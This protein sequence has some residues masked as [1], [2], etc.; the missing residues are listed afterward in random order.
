M[1]TVEIALRLRE[2]GVPLPVFGD[3]EDERIRTIAFRQKE[4]LVEL[5][6]LD[7]QLRL[8]QEEQGN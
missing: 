1:I 3:Y 6:Q 8:Y 7:K 5:E 4:L 2:R